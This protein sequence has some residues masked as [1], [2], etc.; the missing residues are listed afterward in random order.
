M[1]EPRPPLHSLS[2]LGLSHAALKAAILAEIDA[3]QF[4]AQQSGAIADSVADA[5]DANNVEL[6]RQLRHLLFSE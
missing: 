6:F 4:T 5:I 3:Q 2:R 1:D